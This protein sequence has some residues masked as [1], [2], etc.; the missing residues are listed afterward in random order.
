MDGFF[1]SEST[2]GPLYIIQSIKTTE[3][4]VGPNPKSKNWETWKGKI[5]KW[6]PSHSSNHFVLPLAFAFCSATLLGNFGIPQLAFAFPL[7]PK[8]VW[9]LWIN[10]DC[11]LLML[12]RFETLMP[13]QHTYWC[14]CFQTPG[15]VPSAT[16]F[17]L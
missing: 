9:D 16:H 6:V 1:G 4:E 12:R 10:S 2:W 7:G 8:K 14:L 5:I 13:L 3:A 15:L 17:G 11:K